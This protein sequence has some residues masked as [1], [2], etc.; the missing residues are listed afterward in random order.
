MRGG[1]PSR[2]DES[3]PQRVGQFKSLMNGTPPL[4]GEHDAAIEKLAECLTPLEQNLV[5]L[6]AA[7]MEA[8][9]RGLRHLLESTDIMVAFKVTRD[10]FM[11]T[12]ARLERDKIQ[13]DQ[14]RKAAYPNPEMGR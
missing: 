5:A 9:P 12:G 1:F 8:S 11:A 3:Y 14:R 10:S 13:D 6:I 2:P 4:P 7:R